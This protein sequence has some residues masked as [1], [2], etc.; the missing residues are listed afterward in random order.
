[1]DKEF[2]E[3]PA[4][5]KNGWAML[6]LTLIMIVG[7]LAM[8]SVGTIYMNICPRWRRLLPS[9]WFSFLSRFSC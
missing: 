2:N 1:M 3:K 5:E 9:G 6:V 8:F 4:R 7:G